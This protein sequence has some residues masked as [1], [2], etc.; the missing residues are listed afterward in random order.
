MLKVRGLTVEFADGEDTV[1]PLDDLD[2]DAHDGELLLLLGPSGS[3]KTTL[4]SSLAG[5]LTPTSGSIAVAGKEVL[6]FSSAERDSY[7][8]H[9][10]GVVF[11]AFNLIPSLTARENVVVPL[12]LAKVRSAKARQRADELLDQVGLAD[13]RTHRPGQLSGG[14]QQ[15]VAIARALALDPPLLLADEPTAHL[16]FVQVEAVT[17]LLRGLARPGRTVVVATHDDRLLPVADR[18]LELVAAAHRGP[19]PATRIAL[20]PGQGVFDEGDQ[21]RDVYVVS[22][23]AIEIYRHR[24]D[25]S[26]ERINVLRRGTYFG[27]MGPLLGLPRSASA[28]ALSESV[29]TAYDVRDFRH[30][31]GT[32]ERQR[33]RDLQED[34]PPDE[35]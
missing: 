9:T 17:T 3:G 30:R 6:S 23:G 29:V 14:Q 32:S 25:G 5:L 19:P 27:E 11:Q 12:R 33:R 7:R 13:R 8:R 31:A 20:E 15:R 4:L 26:E 1:R 18:T 16:D 10:V 22:S 21:G 2:L 35:H 28:R 24:P 34:A